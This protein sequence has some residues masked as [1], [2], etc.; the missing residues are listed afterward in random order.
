MDRK[1]KL[2]YFNI[3]G[4]AEPI[5]WMFRLRN[6]DFEDE[7]INLDQW[8]EERQRFTKQVGQL[9]ILLIDD[10]IELTQ[11]HTVM[12]YV[13]RE[14]GFN[15]ESELEEAR[16]D[17]AVELVYDLRLCAVAHKD[18]YTTVNP[19]IVS[20]T[21]FRDF[22]NEKS[23]SKKVL[24]RKRLL[25]YTFPLYFSKFAQFLEDSGGEYLAGPNMTY[26]D[27]AVANFL[28]VCEDNI[29]PDILNDFPTLKALK[30]E[31][32]EIPE[33]AEWVAQTKTASASGA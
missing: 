5:R 10:K 26:A 20:H 12:R 27:L 21:I 28:D 23:I 4:L 25:E 3:R 1:Y 31:I 6:V 14:L 13:A 24:M 9:P 29:N 17:E 18:C 30:E 7:R 19:D 15:G 16:A 11:V 22:R 2:T 32:F 8:P 33:V